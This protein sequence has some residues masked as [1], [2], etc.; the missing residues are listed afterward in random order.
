MEKNDILKKINS[1]KKSSLEKTLGIEFID[2]DNDRVKARMEVTPKLHQPDGVLHGGATAALAE[3]VGSVAS[4]LSIDIEKQIVRGT[5]ISAYHLKSIS[6]GYVYAE[7]I[8]IHKG[9]T[10]QLWKINI[11]DEN[12]NLISHCKLSTIILDKR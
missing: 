12:D 9:R 2:L 10:T 3:S 8:A 4:Y 6:S 5:I 7:A 1:L 11:S